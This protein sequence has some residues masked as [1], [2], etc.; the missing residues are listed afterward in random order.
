M[1]KYISVT[2]PQAKLNPITVYSFSLS[3]KRYEHEIATIEFKDWGTEFDVI[4]PGE[5]IIVT[6]T[7]KVESKTFYGYVH[8]IEID[9]SPGKFF[10]TVT[11]VGGSFP[12][13]QSRQTVFKDTTADEVIKKIATI[14][15][16]VCY[17]VPY[18]RVYPQISQA[19][20][21]DWQLMTRLA[22]Q[23]GYT[24]RAEN[25][26][27]YFQPIMEEYTKYRSEAPIFN[28]R[29]LAHPDGSNLY[30]FKPIIS[31]SM[32]YDGDTKAAVA[33][34]GV[35][36]LASVPLTV[37]QQIRNKKTRT[38]QQLEFFDKFATS[39]VA[40]DQT[41]AKFEA[42]AAEN[43]NYFPYRAEAEVLGN[44]NLRPDMPIYL[45]GIG[46]PYSGYWIILEAEHNII[47]QERNLFVYTTT[48]KLGADSLGSS[49][50]WTDSQTINI[51]S[52]KPKRTV[53][54]N[55]KQTKVRPVTALASPKRITNQA[56]KSSFGT[57][58]NRAK[59][60][61]TTA[62]ANTPVT[63]KSKTSSLNTIIP[64]AKKSPIISSRLA[65][66]RVGK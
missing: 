22:K 57:I 46:Q 29:S 11:C 60:A 5:P 59:Q 17:A 48:L 45:N 64:T 28:M 34:S 20:L 9:R 1:F 56:S 30:S 12:M 6:I 65:K 3:Q 42:E 13:K 36:V 37:T 66:K 4:A 43:R 32:T 58:E 35:D 26:E 63:W 52:S 24:L 15:N 55:V 10:A 25:T 14:H 27:L 54:P 62:R 31:E 41:V 19:G 2:F 49:S 8:H 40:L 51:P 7:N 38:K 16:F 23:C 61:S 44:P 47:E 21:S 39:T 33:V 18:A 50:V 53:I